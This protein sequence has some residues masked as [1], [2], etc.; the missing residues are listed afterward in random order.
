MNAGTL[1]TP[2]GI[3][4]NEA[5]QSDTGY[6]PDNWVEVARRRAHVVSQ[7]GSKALNNGSVWYPTARVVRVRKPLDIDESCRVKID[8]VFY[9][10]INIDR[11]AKD[12]ITLN[13]SQVN[14][15]D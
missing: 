12:S 9:E 1:T 6:T 15:C 7:R 14:G 3:Y 5:V 8:G 13:C 11:L 10:I 2:I 4:R